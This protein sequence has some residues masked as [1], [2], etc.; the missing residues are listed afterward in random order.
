MNSRNPYDLEISF[1]QH[2]WLPAPKSTYRPIVDLIEDRDVLAR[3]IRSCLDVASE[4]SSHEE[5]MGQKILAR[6]SP[7]DIL[8]IKQKVFGG[9]DDVSVDAMI[10]QGAYVSEEI[11]SKM[12]LSIV[13]PPENIH[14]MQRGNI[15]V[16]DTYSANMVGSILKKVGIEF[17]SAGK[18][19]DFGCSSGSLTR[20]LKAAEPD[21]QFFGVDPIK[22]SIDWASKNIEGATFKVSNVEPPVDFPD[23]YFNGVTAISIWSHPFINS[24]PPRI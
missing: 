15:Y 1:D 2:V 10:V 14:R 19:L 5:V 21:S 3:I 8:L 22:S 12:G 20:I 24:R 9:R 6:L 13:N 23:G 7:D 11:R 16:G 17:L 18:Y 4:V